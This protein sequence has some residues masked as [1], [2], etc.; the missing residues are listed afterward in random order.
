M[1]GEREMFK[2][3]L[4]SKTP[5]LLDIDGDVCHQIHN[6]VKQ[7]CKPFECFVE[8]WIHDIQ[9]QTNYSTDIL[10]LLKEICFIL[11]VPFR[12]PP[13]RVNHRCLSAF[14][15][16]T[17]SMTLIDQLTLL[18]YAWILNDFRERYEGNMKIIFD[19]YEL[20]EKAK[21]VINAIQTKM[22]QKKLTNKGKERKERIVIKTIL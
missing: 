11:N 1:R 12:K 13:Q 8:R 6:T 16:F 22:K 14:N 5:Q 3:L 17:I 10:Y 20:T 7:F 15:C 21:V 4:R 9:W 18:Y 19:K 2:K